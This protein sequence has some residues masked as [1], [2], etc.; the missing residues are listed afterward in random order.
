MKLL[1]TSICLLALSATAFGQYSFPLVFDQTTGPKN[2]VGTDTVYGTVLSSVPVVPDGQY[3]TWDLTTVQ[4]ASYK[5]Y[6]K[7]SAATNFANA[8]FANLAYVESAGVTYETNLMFSIDATGIKTQGERIDRQA[9]SLAAQGGAPT[10]SLVV[11]KQDVIYSAPQVQM[12]YPCTIGTKW[13]STSNS[14]TN[15]TLSYKLPSPLPPLTNAPAQRKSITTSTNE[16]VGW[17]F[18]R[19][20]RPSDG[21]PCGAEAVLEVKTT[22]SVKD[23]LY[24]NGAPADPLLMQQVGLTQGQTNTVYQKSFYRWNEMLPMVNITFTDATFTTMKDVNMHPQR[25]RYPD[26]VDDI[27]PAAMAQVFPNPGNGNFTVRQPEAVNGT[28][29]YNITDITGKTV[30]TGTLKQAETK[31]SLKGSVAPGTYIM[32][33]AKNGTSVSGHKLEIQ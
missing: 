33:I 2:P 19:I 11:L 23:S 27:A 14:S 13:N 31:I 6:A 17:G 8:N 5:Y 21:K 16:V 28:W 22:L 15:M 18:M 20:K 7:F 32:N 29:T 9:F 1:F 4:L 3:Y 10:D 30:S 24:L 12:P 26:N 25:L